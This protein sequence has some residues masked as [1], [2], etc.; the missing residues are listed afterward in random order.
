ML[1]DTRFDLITGST[2][3]SDRFLARYSIPAIPQPGELINV[4]GD[5]YVVRERAW[6]IGESAD[7]QP[8]QLCAYVRLVS[9]IPS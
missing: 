2:K 4:D 5:P 1:I 9:M 3:E 7:G 8:P 6:A